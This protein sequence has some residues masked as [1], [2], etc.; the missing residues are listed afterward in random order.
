MRKFF[1]LWILLIGGCLNLVADEISF[2][3]T[4]D[5]VVVLNQQ[6]RVNYTLSSTSSQ[7]GKDVRLPDPS[8]FEVLFGPTLSQQASYSQSING[9]S[10]TTNTA[11]YTYVLLAKEEGTFTIPAATIKVGNSEYK[12]NELTVKV[13]PPDQAD[14]AASQNQGSSNQRG[15]TASQP[16]GSSGNI[17]SDDVFIR[18]HVSQKSVYENEGFLVTFKLYS[19]VE[20]A[21]FE[22]IKFPEFEGFIAQEIEQSQN[23]QLNLEHYNGRNYQTVILKQTILYPQR[24]GKLTIDQGKFDAILRLRSQQRV[25]SIFD[26]WFDSY[27]NVNKTLTTPVVN[28]EVKPLPAGKPASFTGAVGDYKMSSSISTTNLKSNSDAVT[29]KVSITG[30][31]NIKL[32]KNPEMKFP[33]DFDVFDPIVNTNARTSTSGVSGSRTI[34]YNAIPRHAGTFTIPKAEFSFFDPQSGSYKTLTTDEYTLNVAQGEG[35]GG[36]SSPIVNATNKEDIRFLGKDIR[37]IKT[38]GFHFHKGK[39]LYGT[40][41]Y[42]LFYIIPLLLFIVFFVLNRKKAAEN[43]NIALVRTKKANKVASKRL[44]TAAKYLKDNNKEAFYDETLKAVWGYLSDKLNIPVAELTKDNVENNLNQYGASE[45]LI[46]DFRQIL[47]TAEFARFAPSQGND[48]MD[49]LYNATTQAIDKM[50]NTLKK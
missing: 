20:V 29:V 13:L 44:K 7:R 39:F 11:V 31:G 10:T 2:T 43:A 27:Q 5:K 15:G 32:I 34:E 12:S 42:A 28:I 38:S 36:I 48:A 6:F 40:M 46:R 21:G 49:E 17:S 14:A 1:F 25:R 47:D 16:S 35:G 41:K 24:S 3:G 9:V 19:L 30:S 50:E 45:D 18:A 8:G 22:N 37:H 26:D 33:N 4:A 23:V